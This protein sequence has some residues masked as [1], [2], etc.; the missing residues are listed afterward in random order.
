MNYSIYTTVFF[1]MIKHRTVFIRFRVL[2]EWLGAYQ[3]IP[4]AERSIYA[5]LP[6]L[7]LEYLTIR[8]GA[9]SASYGMAEIVPLMHSNLSMQNQIDLHTII[10]Q[11][12][13]SHEESIS[14]SHY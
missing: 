11:E 3:Y 6:A 5:P 10:K 7:V 9:V 13:K 12:L 2:A 1:S 4:P 14:K 8:F